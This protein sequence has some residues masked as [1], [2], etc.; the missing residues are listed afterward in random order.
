M[1]S[2]GSAEGTVTPPIWDWH[3]RTLSRLRDCLLREHD[4]RCSSLRAA[5]AGTDGAAEH[6]LEHGSWR[7]DLAI[8]V[9]E[10]E[11]IEAA[12]SRIRTGIHGMGERIE[13][14]TSAAQLQVEPAVRCADTATAAE[15]HT[16]SN[17]DSSS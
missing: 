14:S 10:I 13:E 6:A 17:P 8:A 4:E 5:L 1:Q 3:Y 11:E 2:H 9:E 15:W 7:A 12:L 16:R